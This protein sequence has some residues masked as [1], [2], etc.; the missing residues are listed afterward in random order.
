MACETRDD[1]DEN[2]E[3]SE[4]GEGDITTEDHLTFYQYGREYLRVDDG[5]D[6]KQALI[7]KM[8]TD[9]FFPNVW[10]ISDHGNAHLIEL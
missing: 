7:I 6:Y 10:F 4:P 5:D 9:Q 8:Q 1:E 2:D 3:P